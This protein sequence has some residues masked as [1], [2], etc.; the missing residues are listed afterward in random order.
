MCLGL[1]L[2]VGLFPNLGAG[3]IEVTNAAPPILAGLIV[4]AVMGPS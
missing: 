3:P 1:G 2:L 4:A